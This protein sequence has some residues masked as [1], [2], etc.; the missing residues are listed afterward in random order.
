ML[1]CISVVPRVEVVVVGEHLERL[2]NIALVW[3]SHPHRAAILTRIAEVELPTSSSSTAPTT[4]LAI[5][6]G[7][8]TPR[9]LE[10]LLARVELDVLV[11]EALPHE[12]RFRTL[13]LVRIGEDHDEVAQGGTSRETKGR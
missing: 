2:G 8:C 3:D 4:L 13:R 5:P 7:R 9:D 6:V 12:R 1:R 11:S 10:D